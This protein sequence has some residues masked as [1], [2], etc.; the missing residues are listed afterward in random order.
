MVRRCFQITGRKLTWW[1][2]EKVQEHVQRKRLAEKKWDTERTEESRE[3]EGRGGKGQTK[4][5][6]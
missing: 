5:V 1:W 3:G 4:G 6:Q 2:N